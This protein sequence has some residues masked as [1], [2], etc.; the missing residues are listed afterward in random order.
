MTTT[1]VFGDAHTP[2]AI[3]KFQNEHAEEIEEMISSG[4]LDRPAV[5][6]A[7]KKD[8]EKKRSGNAPAPLRKAA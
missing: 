6:D 7:D 2:E 3:E 4:A 5:S 8:G 1:M